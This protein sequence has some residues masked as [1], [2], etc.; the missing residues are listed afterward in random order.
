MLIFLVPI[1]SFPTST[2]IAK[3]TEPIFEV[4]I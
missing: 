2:H 1:L 3:G 4:M